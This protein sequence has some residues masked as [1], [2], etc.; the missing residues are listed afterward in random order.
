MIV[1]FAGAGASKAVDPD[2]YPTTAEFFSRLPESIS[3]AVLFKN[4]VEFLKGQ[5]PDATIDI[6]LV[7]WALE[8]L[9]DT[10]SGVVNTSAFPGWLFRQPSFAKGPK[11]SQSTRQFLEAARQLSAETE[12]VWSEVNA[13]VYR[14]YQF[15]PST[16][17]LNQ[18]WLPLMKLLSTSGRRVEFFTT[19]YDVVLEEALS[20]VD[21]SVHDGRTMGTQPVLDV[22][23]WQRTGDQRVGLLTKLHGSVDWTRG[24]QR[25]HVGTPL[26]QGDHDR[27]VII[28]PG[29]KGSPDREPFQ[30]F[31]EHFRSCMMGAE[32]AI[33][34]GFAFRD[35]M[36]NE[37]IRRSRRPG[38]KVVVVNP[39]SSFPDL[40]FRMDD[41]IHVKEPFG[42]KAV[43]QLKQYL[44]G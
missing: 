40:P 2:S 36:I 19:N 18:T 3:N 21:L 37:L 10:V 11:G 33:F 16:K 23:L 35:A 9:R 31:H 27:H 5:D 34:I 6:E 13:Q 25:I 30:T 4:T 44:P 24:E 15:P 22:S 29:F 1:V 12:R 7:L 39:M 20:K 26:Y 14:L 43:E 28:Y 38:A 32:L 42:R 17:G 8:E 41:V